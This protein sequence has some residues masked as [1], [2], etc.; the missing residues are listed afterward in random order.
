[1]TTTITQPIQPTTGLSIENYRADLPEELHATFDQALATNPTVSAFEFGRKLRD[2]FTDIGDEISAEEANSIYGPIGLKFDKPVSLQYAQGLA[3]RKKAEANREAIISRGPQ[4]LFPGLARLGVGL[5]GSAFDPLNVVASFVP[6]LGEARVAALSENLGKSAGR[7]AVGA[8]EGFAGAAMLEPLNYLGAYSDQRDYGSSDTLLN[9]AFG[10]A[11]GGGLHMAAGAV[12]DTWRSDKLSSLSRT[13]EP[14][15]PSNI[16]ETIDNMPSEAKNDI[17]RA[18]SSQLENGEPV[19]V[20]SLTDNYFHDMEAR[21]ERPGIKYEVDERGHLV[22][23]LD[24]IEQY[25]TAEDRIGRPATL[26]DLHNIEASMLEAEHQDVASYLDALR[27]ATTKKPKSLVSFLKAEGGIKDQ[28]GELGALDLRKTFSGLVNNK[29]GLTLDK[30]RELAVKA[31]YLRERSG[32]TRPNEST[33]SDL[34]DALSEEARG[35]P[36]YHPEDVARIQEQQAALKNADS[37]D[38]YLVDNGIDMTGK[39]NAQV[40]REMIDKGLLKDPLENRIYD[41]A[42]PE[43]DAFDNAVPEA[44]ALPEDPALDL[45]ELD[46]MINA[47]KNNGT[48]TPE[49]VAVLEEADLLLK[50]A[51]ASERGLLAAATCIYRKS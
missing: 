33:I 10:T 15:P 28:G 47:E 25:R 41:G 12:R 21:S 8:T 18:A 1:M 29:R 9:L 45:Q 48:M 49:E 38:R 31:G 4:G 42:Q 50:E 40:I 36:V 5:A 27:S 51:D 11:L 37:F 22:P 3:D 23:V 39:T 16:A 2:R 17:L 24:T 46:E 30:A 20:S 26:D 13:G 7:L 44:E 35:N 14:P 34:L 43:P 32:P 6:V 19:N